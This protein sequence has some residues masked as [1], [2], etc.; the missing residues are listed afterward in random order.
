MHARIRKFQ[1]CLVPNPKVF[2]PRLNALLEVLLE[3]IHA[4]GTVAAFFLV[5]Q[6]G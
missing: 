6:W 2:E 5:D 4:L 1:F 3:D